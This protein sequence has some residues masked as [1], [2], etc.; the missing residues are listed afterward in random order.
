MQKL[1]MLNNNSFELFLKWILKC[2]PSLSMVLSYLALKQQLFLAKNKQTFTCIGK[3]LG[4]EMRTPNDLVYGETNR[5]SLFVN[6]AVRCIRY[7]LQFPRMEAFKL[8]KKAYRMLHG[9]D[10]RGKRNWASNVCCKL[11]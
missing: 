7:W 6:S 10:E 3:F 1:R 4:V 8:P 5:Y 2:N 11:Y 9:L